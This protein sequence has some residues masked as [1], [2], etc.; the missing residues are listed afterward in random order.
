MNIR[1]IRRAAAAAVVFALTA[2]PLA[3]AQP[4]NPLL[5]LVD[6]AAARLQVAEPVAADKRRTGGPVEDSAREQQVLD[7]VA[8]DARSRQIDP[9]YAAAAFRDQIDATVAVE[10]SRLAQ[11]KLD[12]ASAPTDAPDLA[13]SRATIDAL[14]Q[15]MVAEMAAQWGLLHSPQCGADLDAAKSAVLHTRALDP[16]YRQAIDFATRNYC[17]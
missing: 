2:A 14:N 1:R 15:T 3:H 5:P 4:P 8:A 10:Y 6:A 11:W 9:A 17:R 7:A 13:S 12:P 16:L